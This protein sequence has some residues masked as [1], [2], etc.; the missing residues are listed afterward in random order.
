MVVLMRNDRGRHNFYALHVR[1]ENSTTAK[2][3]SKNSL[4]EAVNAGASAD[5]NITAL[6]RY[7]LNFATGMLN[8]IEERDI[9]EIILGMHLRTTV[10]DS[11]FGSKVDE[12]LRATNKMVIISRCFIPPSTLTRIVVWVPVGA[13]YET[14]FSRWVRA[15][16][17]LTRRVGCR[18]IFNCTEEIRP[19][20][21]GVLHQESIDIRCEFDPIE[22]ADDFIVHTSKILDDDLLVIIGARANSVSYATT[23]TEMPAYLQKYLS[24]NNLMMIYPEQ[25]GE[26]PT[27]TSFVDPMASDIST[28]PSPLWSMMRNYR[29]K[30]AT[31]SKKILKR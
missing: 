2:S 8:V 3:I 19:L 31:I 25:F 27:L 9:T 10:I 20:I 6:D 13:Q 5:I 11:F 28:M 7:D 14:G 30:F 15:I 21:R 1:N 12:L 16:A 22:A 18:V 26:Q 24:R 23:M 17:R 4:T 29:R